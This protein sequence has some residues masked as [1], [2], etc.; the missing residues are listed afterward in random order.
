MFSFNYINKTVG[1]K[2]TA[3]RVLVGKPEETTRETYT[4]MGG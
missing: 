3:Y 4:Y 2:R 1:E